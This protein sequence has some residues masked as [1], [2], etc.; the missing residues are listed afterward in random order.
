MNLTLSYQNKL[1]YDP[2]KT[3]LCLAKYQVSLIH[4]CSVNQFKNENVIL[5]TV[6]TVQGNLN[7]DAGLF[8]MIS[9]LP[10]KK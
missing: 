7:R 5:L 2:F 1:K 9:T 8:M 10:S 3:M 6:L 4:F